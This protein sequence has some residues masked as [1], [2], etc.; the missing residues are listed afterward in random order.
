MKEYVPSRKRK[1]AATTAQ[2]LGGGPA[3]ATSLKSKKKYA[4]RGPVATANLTPLAIVFRYIRPS[5]RNYVDYVRM[6]VREG[7]SRALPFMDAWEKLTK[8]EQRRIMPEDVCDL[9]GVTPSRLGGIV[10]EQ[11]LSSGMDA[12]K[13]LAGIE[14]PRVMAAVAKEAQR[15]DGY[16][17]RALFLRATGS[18]PKE[19]ASVVVHNTVA[20]VAGGG[21]GG[22]VATGSGEVSP[23][24]F[25]NVSSSITKMDR[26]LGTAQSPVTEAA[27][28]PVNIGEYVEIE[29]DEEIEAGDDL[30]P[31]D[32]ED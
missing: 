13:I 5:W 27:R 17:D 26:I 15:K 7:D 10:S 20:S 9:C 14:H 4:S 30:P 25:R 6:A 1:I 21:R 8:S 16:S 28:R 32:E 22:M 31:D 12:S 24:G 19:G 29:P 3:R 11:V 23:G 18:L 2:T